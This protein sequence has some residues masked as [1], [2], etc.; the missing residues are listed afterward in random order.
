M[1]NDNNIY[2][3]LSIPCAMSGEKEVL[4]VHRVGIAGVT[5]HYGDEESVIVDGENLL[6]LRRLID[7]AIKATPYKGRT[8]CQL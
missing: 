6:K 3:T 1:S 2:E 5:F 7:N 4:N 8:E